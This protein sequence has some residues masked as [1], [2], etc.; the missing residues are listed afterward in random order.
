MDSS[1]VRKLIGTPKLV[2]ILG[3]PEELVGGPGS[4]KG[5]QCAKLV[6][7]FGYLHISVG[8]LMRDEIKKVRNS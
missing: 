8:D 7:E 2:C 1:D 5:T 4:G 6:E 3:K